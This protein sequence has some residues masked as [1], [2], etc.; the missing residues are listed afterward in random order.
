MC[1][2]RNPKE[3]DL[4][5]A[6]SLARHALDVIK[7]VGRKVMIPLVCMICIHEAQSEWEERHGAWS[8]KQC[9]SAKQVHEVMRLHHDA[10]HTGLSSWA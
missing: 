3:H 2:A 4:A 6:V 5:I 10:R 8:G 7:I 1:V 9:Q